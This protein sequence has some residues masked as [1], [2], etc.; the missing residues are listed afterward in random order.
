[1]GKGQIFNTLHVLK[2]SNELVN[3]T[4]LQV[5]AAPLRAH[6]SRY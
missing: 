1:M 5:R 3:R 2:M 4:Y 6:K